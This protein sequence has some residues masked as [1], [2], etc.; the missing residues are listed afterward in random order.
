MAGNC[1]CQ[2]G[3]REPFSGGGGLCLECIF[4]GH[5]EDP[6][7]WN[8]ALVFARIVIFIALVVMIGWL[9]ARA[10]GLR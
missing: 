10:A 3:C 8:W 5:M 6:P 4:G 1:V 7:D 2:C 9:V